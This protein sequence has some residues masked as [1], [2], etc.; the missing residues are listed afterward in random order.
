VFR[1]MKARRQFLAHVRQGNGPPFIRFCAISNGDS[2]RFSP[3]TLEAYIEKYTSLV[4]Y[5]ADNVVGTPESDQP[6]ADQTSK[7]ISLQVELTLRQL[8]GF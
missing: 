5:L 7:A 6:P 3:D 2:A 8:S 4:P 1:G